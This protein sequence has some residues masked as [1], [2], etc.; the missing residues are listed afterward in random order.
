ME[1]DMAQ[2][3]VRNLDDAVKAGL[4]RRAQRHGHS[5][6]EEARDILRAAVAVD[7]PP[8]KQLGTWLAGLFAGV[9]LTEEISEQRGQPPRPAGFEG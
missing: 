3:V 4:R 1:T 6:E 8:P 9:G 7:E 2:L 5:M